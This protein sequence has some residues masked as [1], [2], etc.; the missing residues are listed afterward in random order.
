MPGF[1]NE[2]PT[3]SPFPVFSRTD[4][5]RQ[6][7]LRHRECLARQ[8]EYYSERAITGVDA[9]LARLMGRLDQL[10]AREDAEQYLSALLRRINVVTGLSYWIDPTM[11]H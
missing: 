10:S 4:F 2:P 8:R 7:I 9:A 5:F 11:F 3:A 1:R 6:E